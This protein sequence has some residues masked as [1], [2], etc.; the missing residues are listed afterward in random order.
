VNIRTKLILA[1]LLVSLP[2]L[3]TVAVIA[4]TLAQQ[5]LY[6]NIGEQSLH[7]VEI[8]AGRINEYLHGQWKDIRNW[9]AVHEEL[10]RVNEGDR[11]GRISALL[12]KIKRHQ[13]ELS[14]LVCADRNGS[15]VAA[16]DQRLL[17][18]TLSA[19]LGFTTAL[20]GRGNLQDVAYDGLVRD[21]TL[22][23]LTPI[24]DEGDG[25][26]VVGVLCCALDWSKIQE[27]FYSLRIRG[28]PRDIGSHFMLVNNDGLA[29]VGHDRGDMFKDNLIALGM[30]SALEAQRG[31]MGYLMETS[32]HGIECL[33]AYTPV[34]RFRDLPSLGWSVVLLQDTDSLFASLRALDKV[35]L[36][37]LVGTIGCVVAASF[38]TMRAISKPILTLAGAADDIRLG[39]HRPVEVRSKDE[40]GVL[41]SSFN[42]MVA[43][44]SQRTESL[45]SE[46]ARR[47]QAEE[48]LRAQK[49]EMSRERAKLQAIFD[50]VPVGMLLV[51]EQ[52]RI[53]R[54]NDVIA[55][56]IGKGGT[57]LLNHQPGD[58]LCCIHASETPDGCGHAAAC[59]DCPTRN[60]IGQVLREGVT[61]RNAEV[62]M[63][64]AI[65]NE[66]RQLCVALSATPL[67]L[68]REKH[69]LLAL[70]DISQ[71]QQAEQRYRALF[72]SSRDAIMTLA[73]PSWRFTSGNPATVR[74]FGTRDEA[75]FTS[76]D[77]WQLSPET[78]PDGRPSADKAKEMIE[79][80]MRQGS[81]FFEWTHKRLGGDEFPATVL[82]TGLEI[83][84]QAMLQ[85]TVRDITAQ[86]RTEE[87]REQYTLALEGRR[88]AMEELYHAGELANLAKSEFLS[89]MSHEIRT[90][91]TA[92]LGF[93]D[94]LRQSLE[95]CSV[96]PDH[97]TCAT[98]RENRTHMETI[99]RNGDHLLHIINDILDL[100]KIEAGKLQVEW[101]PCSP[102][103]IL[104]DVVSLLRVRAKA[105]G[106]A[107]ELDFAGPMPDTIL[108]DPARLRQILLNL[109]GNAIKFTEAGSVRLIARVVDAATGEPMFVCEVTDTG[110]GMTA[111]GVQDL[112]QPFHQADA[113]TSRKFGGTG[114]GLAI[115][116][117]LATLL[118]G[119]ITVSSQLGKGSTFTLTVDPGP[120]S[121]VA[122][123][124]HPA[125]SLAPPA[126]P[127]AISS[128]VPALDCRI[129]LAEDGADNKRLIAFVLSKAG[130][131]VTAV[132]NGQEAL[133]AAL[134]TFPNGERR[135]D[136]PEAFDVIL[137]D[138]QMPVMDGYEATR[139]LR[140][141]GYAGPIIALTAHAMAD[142]RQK[143]LEAGCDDYVTKPIDRVKLVG[144]IAGVLKEKAKQPSYNPAMVSHLANALEASV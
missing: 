54:A 29:I 69:A 135:E 20:K 108:T 34:E 89:N 88:Q 83:G 47:K 131:E 138:M 61:I 17:G 45:Q 136:G 140:A 111:E 74:L 26:A 100:S 95:C 51:D 90:P 142:D 16:S 76:L 50:S 93:T 35:V 12:A 133:E 24:R 10:A 28:R 114:L 5:T 87:L 113:S 85:A 14:Y 141:S 53:T 22:K 91:M 132:E 82:L 39:N 62:T 40:I 58:G 92:I 102:A 43:E 55:A 99:R 56:L 13:D 134:A 94:L 139:R 107:L 9:A 46:V 97:A 23:V 59:R 130:A 80:A 119:D 84:G 144:M 105:K 137:M 60:A 79:T 4:R 106:L 48:D 96:C 31:E 127:S 8:A 70:V 6:Q 15:V 25:S 44:V 101:R 63:Q 109:I 64:L 128:P 42:K 71:R 68:E 65:G 1:L 129:L 57:E 110:I 75:E 125:E 112:F 116:K 2:P 123:H 73:P 3:V 103:A 121:D 78:Q 30:R 143:C 77:P 37:A 115:S 72:E 19:D 126:S 120:L 7:I 98:R 49:E 52:T 104:A 122:F 118:R 81:H 32:E 38:L 124:D 67:E 66:Q 36:A 18:A 21:Y 86:K 33:S 117:R 41:T 27:M 11:D